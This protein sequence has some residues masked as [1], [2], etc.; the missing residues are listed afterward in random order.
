MTKK[1]KISVCI[2]TYNGGKYIREQISSIL[3]QLDDNDEVIISD[4]GSTDNTLDIIEKYNDTRLKI[5]HNT[6]RKG[7]VGN[8]EN[9]LN[10]CSGD[11]IFLS[12]QDDVWLPNKVRLSLESLKDYEVVVSNCKVVDE[13]L[14]I[15]HESYFVLNNSK[16]GFFKNFYR[17]SYLGCC[18]AFRRELLNDILPFPKKLFL[19]HD[20][21]IGFIADAK[22][23]VKFIDTPCMLFR[24][25]GQNT[26]TTTGVSNQSLYKKIRDRFQLLYLGL[27]RLMNL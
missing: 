12:D 2:S 27:T 22:Y 24:R 14:Q 13:H 26:S 7:V 20:W 4:D 19:F 17:S 23:K 21:W 5:F 1:I 15:I 18:L 9:A 6:N 11:I 8:F 25:H 3:P 10:I 16:Q